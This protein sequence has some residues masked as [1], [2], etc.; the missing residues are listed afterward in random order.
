MIRLIPPN[1][2]PFGPAQVATSAIAT[3]AGSR[4]DWTDELARGTANS[5][6]A[7]F[8]SGRAALAAALHALRR[9]GRTEVVVPAY[10]CWSVPAAVVRA[11]LKVRAYDIDPQ[12]LAMSARHLEGLDLS[13]AA[14]IL[15]VHLFAPD[16]ELPALAARLA[17]SDPRA[18]II[19]D[20][21]QAWPD[22]APVPAISAR[23]WSFGRGK[24]LP[25]GGGGALVHPAEWEVTTPRSRR[26]GWSD[27]LALAVTAM[28]ARPALYR[29]PEALPFLGL[30]AT[31]YQPAFDM[32]R[33]FW[34]WQRELG[35]RCFP[36]LSSWIARR[37][38]AASALAAR[39][40]GCR[41]WVVPAP[42][43][44]PGPLRF[45]VLAPD[46]QSRD[47]ALKA[48][49]RQGV[50]ASAM[51]PGTICQIPALRPHFV[52]H[53]D[54][55]PGAESVAARLLTLPV[56]PTLTAV[57]LER[58]GRAVERAATESRR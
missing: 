55:F 13:R 28:L 12:T 51:Y 27:A 54:G 11:G 29:L 14:G 26:G 41:G 40:A 44:A 50:A 2:L 22:A 5:A 45:P 6:V 9:E 18:P 57:E 30:G 7:L 24:P 17:A 38:I 56:Y 33:P 19:E 42:A 8:G 23:L 21:A 52:N 46:R 25:L 4:P 37:T 48:L 31:V 1:A 39:V 58:V 34:T 15:L 32:S 35:S 36:Q 53:S 3:G 49:H 16:P 47:V 20:A 10:T 43:R